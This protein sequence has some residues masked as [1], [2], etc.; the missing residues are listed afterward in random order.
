MCLEVEQVKDLVNKNTKCVIPVHL[1]GNASQMNELC[2]FAKSK[3]IKVIEDAAQGVGVKVDDQS[4]RKVLPI[5]EP[6]KI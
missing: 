3:N 4:R 5:K 2:K 6:W 1:F